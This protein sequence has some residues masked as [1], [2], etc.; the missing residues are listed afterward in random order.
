ML[1]YDI[2]RDEFIYMNRIFL[3]LFIMI[4]KYVD[5]TDFQYFRSSG[6]TETIFLKNII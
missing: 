1:P 6:N 4:S 3:D 5:E 2:K